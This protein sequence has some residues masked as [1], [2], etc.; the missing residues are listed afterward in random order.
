M[1]VNKKMKE[2]EILVE[3]KEPSDSA[4]AKLKKLDT[5]KE[6]GTSLVIDE[7]YYTSKDEENKPVFSTTEWFRIRKKENK[8]LVT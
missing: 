4:L 2:I 7:Y 8:A 6:A 5:I 1:F 3:I